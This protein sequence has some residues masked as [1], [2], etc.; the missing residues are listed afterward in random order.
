MYAKIMIIYIKGE[1]DDD[2]WTI[3]NGLHFFSMIIYLRTMLIFAMTL[4]SSSQ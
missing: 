3:V 2:P 4:T 1:I